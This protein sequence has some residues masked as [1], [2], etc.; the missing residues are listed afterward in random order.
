MPRSVALILTVPVTV[1]P[2]NIHELRGLVAN[3]EIDCDKLGV[4]NLI[5]MNPRLGPLDWPGAM[6]IIR[7]DQSRIDLRYVRDLNDIQLEF[8]M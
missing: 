1:T 2:F 8:G 4:F 5:H 7:S 3:G 6:Y